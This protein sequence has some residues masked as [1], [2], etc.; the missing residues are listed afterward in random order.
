MFVYICNIFSY[1][2]L[3]ELLLLQDA[4]KHQRLTEDLYPANLQLHGV[5]VNY[6]RVNLPQDGGPVVETLQEG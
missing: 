3:L 1:C 2:Y 6:H 4:A 5:K